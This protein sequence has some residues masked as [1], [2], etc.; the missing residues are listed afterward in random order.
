MQLSAT[1]FAEFLRTWSI[2]GVLVYICNKSRS[3]SF[4]KLKY[5]DSV[6]DFIQ[7]SYP[8]RGSYLISLDKSTGAVST[9]FFKKNVNWVNIKM[10]L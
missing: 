10:Y 3:L 9:S 8:F 1:V 6:S 7:K 5:F 4:T 2:C